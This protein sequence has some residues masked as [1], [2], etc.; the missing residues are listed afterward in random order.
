MNVFLLGS[1]PLASDIGEKCLELMS[2]A[3][4][5]SIFLIPG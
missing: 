5:L 3:L 1:L 2:I 4:V